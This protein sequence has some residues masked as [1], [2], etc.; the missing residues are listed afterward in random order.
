MLS[1]FFT[2]KGIV[3]LL[4]RVRSDGFTPSAL[5]R[6][7]RNK[8]KSDLK[9][10]F[11]RAVLGGYSQERFANEL[12]ATIRARKRNTLVTMR[13]LML[14]VRG[15]ARAALATGRSGRFHNV[16]TIDSRTSVICLGFVG[17]SWPKPYSDIP[18]KPPR[19]ANCRSHLVFVPDGAEPP[20][21]RSF[22]EVWRDGGDQL[23]RQL[24]PKTKYE[25]FKRGDL[26]IETIKQYEDAIL[27][28][29]E[30]LGL[31]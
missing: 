6:R 16:S 27:H 3:K 10:L 2:R 23:H 22:D 13:G 20:D 31:E 21:D 15:S 18:D 7:T 24:L 28:T 5:L 30:D 1:E 8:S 29:L 12:D 26:V 14:S 17:Q 11:R 9:A 19:H 4:G 25:A